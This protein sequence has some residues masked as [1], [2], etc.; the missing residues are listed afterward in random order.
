MKILFLHSLYAPHVAGG[1]EVVVRQLA[2]G[3]HAVE[4]LRA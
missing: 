4:K 3:L 2:E 1:A